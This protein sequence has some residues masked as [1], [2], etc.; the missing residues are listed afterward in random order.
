MSLCR[1]PRRTRRAFRKHTSFAVTCSAT[2]LKDAFTN[3]IV[4]R[5]RILNEPA[6]LRLPGFV[7]R[8]AK[9]LQVAAIA[10]GLA[11]EA[12]LAAVVNDLV[13]EIDPA[14]LRQD[15]HKLLLNFLRRI[16]FRQ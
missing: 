8:V 1:L 15:A 14:V 9:L 7:F 10:L 12:D 4:R 5:K 2:T 6:A 3:P 11:C 16:A 13:A